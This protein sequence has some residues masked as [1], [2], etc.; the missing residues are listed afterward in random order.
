MELGV[1]DPVPALQA[2]TLPDQ[3]QQCF[4]C[5][6]QACQKQ[7]ASLKRFAV[8]PADGMQLH[9]PAGAVPDLT[10]VFRCRFGPQLPGDIATVTDLMI[11]CDKR[12]LA[13][14][15]ELAADLAVQDCLVGLD[16]QEEVGSLLLELLKNGCWVWSASAW[17]KMPSRSS[18]PSSCLSTA[19]SWLSP[20]A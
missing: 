14:A 20:V 4:C 8:A 16:R 10:D 13:L 1:T 19:R 18:S 7:M 11:R 6:A 5:G 2:P 17:I 12:D 9:N 15:L 3:S